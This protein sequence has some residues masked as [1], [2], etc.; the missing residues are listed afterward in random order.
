MS[1]R[2]SQI[3]GERVFAAD[4]FAR[5]GS[6]RPA[7]RRCRG[8]AAAAI[9]AR[10]PTMPRSSSTGATAR[11]PASRCRAHAAARRSPGRRPRA[12]RSA[13][14]A[15]SVSTRSGAMTV[16]PSG[17]CQPDA[18]FARNLLGATPADA[19]SPVASRI[20]RL[21]P[22]GDPSCR[23]VRP[24][25]SRSRRDR[26]RRARAAPPA[27]SSRGRSRTPARHGAIPLEVGGTITSCGHSRTARAI[28]MADRTPNARAS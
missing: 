25:R 23:A 19:V 18:I 5:R 24:R 8:R 10:L 16:S 15:E 20:A 11:P 17:F 22:L 21:Q 3:A 28:G 13:A 12:R 26:P 2:S 9:R 1:A 6:A 7:D 27:A 14:P 4:R